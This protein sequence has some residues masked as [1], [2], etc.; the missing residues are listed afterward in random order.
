MTDYLSINNLRH[1]IRYLHIK[2]IFQLPTITENKKWH[3]YSKSSSTHIENIMHSRIMEL[4]WL[5]LASK[6]I[7]MRQKLIKKQTMDDYYMKYS[8][9]SLDVS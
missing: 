8:I 3:Y 9:I 6:Q 5:D 1:K 2:I 4:Q 7:N